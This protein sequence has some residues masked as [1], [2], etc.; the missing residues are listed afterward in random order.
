MA[1]GLLRFPGIT[2]QMFLRLLVAVHNGS[3]HHLSWSAVGPPAS[4]FVVVNAASL[5]SV[6]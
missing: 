3:V 6:C 4:L 5:E 2:Y 1:G